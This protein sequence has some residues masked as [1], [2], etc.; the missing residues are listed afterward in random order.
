MSSSGNTLERG[1]L[2]A[3]IRPAPH[4]LGLQGSRE[5]RVVG[6]KDR[7]VLRKPRQGS[8]E[9]EEHTK[10]GGIIVTVLL[11]P[12]LSSVVQQ[13]ECARL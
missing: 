11:C 13:W 7:A 5:T 9:E 4:S 6:R 12:G 2:A 10:C 1:S 8:K 3:G